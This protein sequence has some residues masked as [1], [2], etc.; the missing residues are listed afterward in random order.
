MSF[1]NA[2]SGQK[3]G[4]A[5]KCLKKIL[6]KAIKNRRNQKSIVSRSGF[7]HDYWLN[8]KYLTAGVSG[9]KLTRLQSM[10]DEIIAFSFPPSKPEDG[11]YMASEVKSLV[12]NL[13][14]KLVST[15]NHNIIIHI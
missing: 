4:Q 13:G 12:P 10:T 2:W 3:P 15:Q 11:E 14:M 5:G 8:I 1:P 9:A 6:S 7:I